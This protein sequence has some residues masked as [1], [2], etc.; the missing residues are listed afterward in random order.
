MCNCCR[1]NTNNVAWLN[2]W[3]SILDATLPS[4]VCHTAGMDAFYEASLP[5]FRHAM[6][7]H[8][9]EFYLGPT[10]KEDINIHSKPYVQFYLDHIEDIAKT[11]PILLCAHS[12]TQH[13]AIL[14]GGQLL[15]RVVAKGLQL[16]PDD[17]KYS[18]A[19]V[20]SPPSS[21]QGTMAFYIDLNG[22]RGEG[23]GSNTYTDNKENK[24][25]QTI[26][27]LK[28]S[29]KA[30][31][32]GPLYDS[33]TEEEHQLFISEVCRTFQFNNKIITSYKVGLLYPLK[34]YTNFGVHMCRQHPH[35]VST[36]AV[37]VLAVMIWRYYHS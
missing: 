26:A 18:A 35:I 34:A 15:K 19:A 9:L 7:A 14:S 4:C 2:E 36:L 11:T 28:R 8:D 32:D 1:N 10:W 23:S 6:I 25:I 24:N 30:A 33:M 12:Y 3:N 5:V 13:L 17:D 16:R 21:S 37:G 31:L 27:T 22:T 20:S 29:L